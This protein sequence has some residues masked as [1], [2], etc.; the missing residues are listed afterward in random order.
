MIVFN[1]P[2]ETESGLTIPVGA[3]SVPEIT[4]F[5][6]MPREEGG[7][8][9]RLM[10]AKLPLHISKTEY[11]SDFNR[12]KLIKDRI[13]QTE[14]RFEKELTAVEHAAILENGT[15]AEVWIQAMIEEQ[16]TIGAGNTSIVDPFAV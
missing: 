13:K 9:I 3:C 12:S 2:L 11:L 14:V 4:F 15:L 8:P 10:I 7:D 1:L 5:P 6:A 16:A